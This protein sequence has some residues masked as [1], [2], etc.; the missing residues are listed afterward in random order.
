MLHA[1]SASAR[2]GAGR[3][4]AVMQFESFVAPPVGVARS[5]RRVSLREV[6]A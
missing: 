5:E 2:R 6:A 3:T 4:A 1:Q